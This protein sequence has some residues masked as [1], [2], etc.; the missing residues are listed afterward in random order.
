MNILKLNRISNLGLP[1][2]GAITYEKIHKDNADYS[3]N[4]LH[5]VGYN[6]VIAL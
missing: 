4:N 1:C 2:I 6:K 5:P 3:E